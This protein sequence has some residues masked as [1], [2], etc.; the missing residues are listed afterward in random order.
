MQ[1]GMSYGIDGAYPDSLQPALLKVYQ[2]ASEEWH[3]FLAIKDFERQSSVAS[4]LPSSKPRTSSR[5]RGKRHA[6]SSLDGRRAMRQRLS[7]SPPSEDGILRFNA[8]T[9]GISGWSSERPVQPRCDPQSRM[10]E[11]L[12][13]SFRSNVTQSSSALSASL[14]NPTKE[15]HYDSN[16]LLDHDSKS[17]AEAEGESLDKWMEREVKWRRE[18]TKDALGGLDPKEF[19]VQP[20]STRLRQ[21]CSVLTKPGWLWMLSGEVEDEMLPGIVLLYGPTEFSTLRQEA[22]QVYYNK[23]S[24]FVD[25]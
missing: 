16:A 15:A 24:F 12:N 2:W 14:I 20:R 23:N 3:K 6:S 1:R 17:E 8:V 18:K 25:S 10:L 4:A 19:V 7:T 5:R 9:P 11:P 13:R 21:L 22:W